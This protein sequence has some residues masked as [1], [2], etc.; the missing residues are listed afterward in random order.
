MICIYS[1]TNKINGKVYVGQSDD[2]E[3]RKNHHLLSLRSNK[4]YIE[5]LQNDFNI[6]GEHNFE[7]KV[8][9]N[10]QIDE[11][12]FY[13]QYYI[14]Q[15]N[16]FEDNGGYNL[17][18][19]G[20]SGFTV[21]KSTKEKLSKSIKERFKNDKDYYDKI[22][23]HNKELW[24]NENHRK[25]R[26]ENMK[27]SFTEERRQQIS[28]SAKKM[29]TEEKKELKSKEMKEKYS[30]IEERQKQSE[31]VKE[32]MSKL[33][34]EKLSRRHISKLPVETL[35]D[36]VENRHLTQKEMAEKYNTSI[37]NAKGI[38]SG[39]HWIYDY[40]RENNIP[41]KEL[42]KDKKFRCSVSTEVLLNIVKDKDMKRSELFTKYDDVSQK[43]IGQIRNGSHWI[44]EYIEKNNIIL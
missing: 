39:S 37:A 38:K 35:L 34:K 10:C 16:S 42:P 18:T 13:E 19:G 43:I 17:N 33:P 3:R 8:L 4:H 1:I 36:M 12:D 22:A 11:L 21:S 5:K 29:W 28:E 44:Y 14:E 20:K 9:I 30:N 32:A 7:F 6:Y 15:L 24:L 31:I 40:M 41:I 26:I 23:Q 2:Y 25:Q 27:A